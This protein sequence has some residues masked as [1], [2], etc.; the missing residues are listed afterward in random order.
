MSTLAPAFR[1]AAF[2]ECLVKLA[3]HRLGAKG[4][5]TSLGKAGALT[6]S[7]EVLGGSL[8]LQ[9]GAPTWWKCTWLLPL[10]AHWMFRF[11]A[12]PTSP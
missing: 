1:C 8:E 6:D 12:S 5:A 10:G 2:V 3:L 7:A 4:R 9:R 11:A